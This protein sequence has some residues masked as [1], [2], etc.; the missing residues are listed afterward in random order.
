ML[1]RIRWPLGE[2]PGDHRD[3][4]RKAAWAIASFASPAALVCILIGVWIL[5]A[6]HDWSDAFPVATGFFSNWGVW[7]VLGGLLLFAARQL[8]EYSRRSGG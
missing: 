5:A 3:S 6:D 4:G 8:K 7:V 2:P 1:V